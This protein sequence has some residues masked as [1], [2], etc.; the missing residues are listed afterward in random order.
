MPMIK[1]P[2][3]ALEKQALGFRNQRHDVI[4]SNIANANTPGY[5]AFDIVLQERV[6]GIKPL[7]PL[8]T[9]PRHMAATAPKNPPGIQIQRSRDPARL[10]GNNVSLDKEL[11]KMMENRVMYQVGMELMDRWGSLKRIAREM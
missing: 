2:L 9:D 3:S 1:D 5:K 10:D 6:E 7:Q 8:R 11:V 4:A